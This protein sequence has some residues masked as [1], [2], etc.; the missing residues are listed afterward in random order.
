VSYGKKDLG[1]LGSPSGLESESDEQFN[2]APRIEH[3][4][5]MAIPSQPNTHLSRRTLNLNRH[6][7][8]VRSAAKKKKN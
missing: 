6:P 2:S 7:P 8:G 4:K 5:M 1:L 3:R